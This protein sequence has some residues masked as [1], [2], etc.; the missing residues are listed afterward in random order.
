MTKKKP[1]GRPFKPGNP[2]GPGRSPL[3]PELK[4]ARKLNR[5]QVEITL[6]RIIQMNE[7]EIEVLMLDPYATA[8]EKITARIV[9]EASKRGDHFRLDFLFNRLI[10][11]VQDNIKLELPKPTV[12]K[13]MSGEVIELGTES[14]GDDE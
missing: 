2:G 3:P 9:Q 11:K 7:T 14:R 8:M 6:S 13:R 10:G 5:S 4:A 1:T 12:I